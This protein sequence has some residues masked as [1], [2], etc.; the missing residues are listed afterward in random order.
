M[1]ALVRAVNG[2]GQKETTGDELYKLYKVIGIFLST[3]D[4]ALKSLINKWL[5]NIA[6]KQGSFRQSVVFVQQL[7][8]VISGAPETKAA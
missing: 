2:R 3:V 4:S 7:L 8:L 5:A 1:A 6:G